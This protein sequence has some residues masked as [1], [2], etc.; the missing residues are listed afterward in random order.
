MLP[1]LTTFILN[2]LIMLAVTKLVGKQ[3]QFRWQ[4]YI[5]LCDS[6]NVAVIT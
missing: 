2:V 1:E 5:F 6:D 3:I 4:S